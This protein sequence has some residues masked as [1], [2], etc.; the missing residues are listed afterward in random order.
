MMEIRKTPDTN[1]RREAFLFIDGV[2]IEEAYIHIKEPYCDITTKDYYSSSQ[3]AAY[4]PSE[5]PI[6]PAQLFLNEYPRT[7]KHLDKPSGLFISREFKQIEGTNKYEGTNE[8]LIYLNFG[9][10]AL[11][12]WRE[13]YTFA[14]YAYQI[15]NQFKSRKDI[16]GFRLSSVHDRVLDRTFDE[17]DTVTGEIDLDHI[18][19]SQI[20]SFEVIFDYSS[21]DVTIADELARISQIIHE[22]H[23]KAIKILLLD[24]DLIPKMEVRAVEPEKYKLFVNGSVV[25]DANVAVYGNPKTREPF[26]GISFEE[27]KSLKKLGDSRFFD[28]PDDV[29]WIHVNLDVPIKSLSGLVRSGEAIWINTPDN[30]NLS[31]M[32]DNHT[33]FSNDYNIMFQF[34]IDVGMWIGQ[35]SPREYVSKIEEAYSDEPDIYVHF[36]EYEEYGFVISYRINNLEQRIV[37]EALT[38]LI[39]VRNLLDQIE[40]K[41]AAPLHQNSIVK[42]FN[43]PAEVAISCEQYLQYFIQFLL[44]LGVEATS[45]LQHKAGEVLF[46]VTPTDDREALDKIQE[47]LN[48]Y[49]DLPKSPVS[50]DMDNDIAV[51]R[52]EMNV[53]RLQGDLK[54]AA[55]EIRANNIAIEGQRLIIDLQKSLLSGGIMTDSLKDVT[56]KPEDD[57]PILGGTVT[58]STIGKGVKFNLGEIFRRMKREFK[59]DK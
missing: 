10:A 27:Y 48:I 43:F 4:S 31:S 8:F 38:H 56:P 46:T 19:R 29:A 30:F 1:S 9:A 59:K 35:C 23:N 50:N 51:Q 37:G 41:V 44:D 13:S 15:C 54:L 57:E 20:H 45:E 12:E 40:T 18:K 3:L 55:A 14:D 22:A 5:F 16:K 34:F 39:T 58:L 7:I 25:E 47:A 17:T 32:R 42:S 2:L 36:H 28:V 26:W 24:I 21:Y 6:P 33:P 11:S 52:L 49:L 53:H